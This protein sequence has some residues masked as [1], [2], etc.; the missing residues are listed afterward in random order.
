[1]TCIE[2]IFRALGL[3]SP[4][5][6]KP[7][8]KGDTPEEQVILDLLLAGETEGSVLLEKSALTVVRFNQ[9]ITML[10]ITGKVRPL[11]ANLWALA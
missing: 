7:Q 6:R 3:Q 5:H 2:D 9:T 10:E 11:G 4:A 1:M 8:P